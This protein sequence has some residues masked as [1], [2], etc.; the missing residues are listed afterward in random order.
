MKPDTRHNLWRVAFVAVL[1]LLGAGL[2]TGTAELVAA[3]GV[4]A[5]TMVIVDSAGAH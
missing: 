4:A 2:V 1:V 5:L 3:A